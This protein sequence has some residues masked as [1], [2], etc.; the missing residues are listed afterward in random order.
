MRQVTVSIGGREYRL[1][2][3]TVP[4][5][6]DGMLPG[7][8]EWEIEIGFGKGR[9]LIRRAEAEP[10]RRFLGIEMASSYYRLACRRM[11]RRS[12][13]NLIL[14]RSEALFAI[15]AL[16]PA[17]FASA[18]H[19]YFP[20]PWPKVRHQKRRLFDP[21]TVD[22]VLSLL[23]PGGQLFFATDCLDYGRLVREILES[24]PATRVTVLPGLWPDGPRTNYEVKYERAQR[25]I[26]RLQVSWQPQT[27]SP[28]LHPQ[29]EAGV[30]AATS[31]RS[32][33][34]DLSE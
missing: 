26:L 22:L 24:H 25:P 12:V 14:I 32:E 6:L 16:L 10:E 28:V 9:Y 23:R 3:L 19:V 4:M 7:D 1:P 11:A 27:P 30:L 8:A 13:D 18:V 2:E 31:V 34:L 5:A 33:E 21:E 17:G 15:S 20:D 29:G